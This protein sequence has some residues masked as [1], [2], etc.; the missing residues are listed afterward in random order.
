VQLRVRVVDD[1]QQ[2]SFNSL[3][4]TDSSAWSADRPIALD[5]ALA[6]WV[7]GDQVAK[8]QLNAVQIA[9]ILEPRSGDSALYPG[10]WT[11]RCFLRAGAT[12]STRPS[13]GLAASTVKPPPGDARSMFAGGNG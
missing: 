6:F 4:A 5:N 7:V 12:Q 8:A 9:E 2:A 13:G 11:T 10:P 3:D 1:P